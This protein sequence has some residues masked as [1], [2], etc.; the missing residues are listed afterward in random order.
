M[1]E[2]VDR[3]QHNATLSLDGEEHPVCVSVA[4]RYSLWLSFADRSIPERLGPQDSNVPVDA[5][6][7][8]YRDTSLTTGSSRLVRENGAFRFIPQVNIYDFERFFSQSRGQ[9]LETSM[10]D[11]PLMLS[12]KESINSRFKEYVANVSYD[13]NVY[14]IMLDRVDSEIETEPESARSILQEAIIAV[15]SKALC[16]RVD[17]AI[18]E[19][20]EVVDGLSSSEHRRHGYYLR[21]QLWTVIMC[22]PI[23]AR[24]NLKPRGYIG[25]SEMMR[26]IYRNTWEGETTF[27]RI[28]HKHAVGQPAAEAVRNRRADMARLV[29]EYVHSHTPAEGQRTRLLSVA[30]GPAMELNEVV[31]STAAADQMHLSL[32]DQDDDA[33]QEAASVVSALEHRYST[34][35]SVDFIRESVRTLL[36]TRELQERWGK[37]DFIYSMGL[38]DYLTRPVAA[39][40]IRKL[41]LLLEPDG[42]M[43]IGNFHS[44]NPTRNF[45]AYWLDWNII[46]RTDTELAELATDLEGAEVATELDETGIQI[47]LRIRR[48]S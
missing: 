34:T 26:M 25:D 16:K 47:F 36:V 42:E 18:T 21:R 5:L 20:D 39:A 29:R 22:P 27:G 41:Y 45:M 9:L 3:R 17:Q 43:I 44:D 40:V 48:R 2:S 38:F 19:L 7:I 37:F 1:T 32:L 13:L 12:Y 31:A 35:M 10:A 28:L 14:K 33:L 24:T 15:H 11:L 4:S 46:Y 23:I 8:E 6:S 30:C